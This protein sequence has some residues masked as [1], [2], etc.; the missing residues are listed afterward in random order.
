[1]RTLEKALAIMLAT[2]LVIIVSGTAYGVLTGSRTRKLARQAVPVVAGEAVFDTLGRIRV[3]TADSPPAVAVIDLAFPYPASDRQFREELQQKRLELHSV[4]SS[5]FASRKASELR[6]G[7]EAAIKA[8]LR[9]TLNGML[10]LGSIDTLYF[11][12]FQ[13]VD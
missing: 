3:S 13:I 11:S 12:E 6:P 9:D 7:D 5:F 2:V 8:A 4:A 1:M 10:T